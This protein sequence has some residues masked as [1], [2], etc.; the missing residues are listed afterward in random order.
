MLYSTAF[1]K[2]HVLWLWFEQRL[3]R[4]LRFC[5]LKNWPTFGLDERWTHKNAGWRCRRY[6]RNSYSKNGHRTNTPIDLS[7]KLLFFYFYH[8]LILG[9]GQIDFDRRGFVGQWL[10]STEIPRSVHE[11]D[12]IPDL[13]KSEYHVKLTADCKPILYLNSFHSFH[14]PVIGWIFL[15]KQ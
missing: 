4:F 13:D 2:S 6:Y 15:Q 1:C 8:F 7:W 9:W 5:D 10:C 3:A 11:N 14:F 12:E